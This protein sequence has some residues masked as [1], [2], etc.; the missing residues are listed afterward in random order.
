MHA[1]T[2]RHACLL[3]TLLVH[4]ERRYTGVAHTASVHIT[5]CHTTSRTWGVHTRHHT[6]PL[7]PRPRLLP[8]AALPSKH[9]QWM[10]LSMRHAGVSVIYV[11]YQAHHESQPQ[12]K[13]HSAGLTHQT[14]P[15]H[16]YQA[17]PESPSAA[18][19]SAQTSTKRHVTS[20]PTDR[21]VGFTPCPP[22][23]KDPTLGRHC[24][25]SV[26]VPTHHTRKAPSK[27]LTHPRPTHPSL[28][29]TP[30]KLPYCQLVCLLSLLGV[31]LMPNP[32]L[33][34]CGWCVSNSIHRPVCG[35]A[36]CCVT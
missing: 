15:R 26:A 19:T 14:Q 34:C 18:R 33:S 11:S 12:A 35:S 1:F 10:Q 17:P 27:H 3:T 6:A 28:P 4:K 29:Q 32:W 21:H 23:H 25:A 31:V 8:A 22:S 36:T 13:T 20:G 16:V 9:W 30:T 2:H 5:R 7:T 24:C